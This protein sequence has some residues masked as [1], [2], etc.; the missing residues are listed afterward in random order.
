[1]EERKTFREITRGMSLGQK[2]MYFWYYYKWF[3]L[4]G[5]GFVALAIWIGVTIHAE[6]SKNYIAIIEMVNCETYSVDESDFFS[7]FFEK[8]G[9]D[10]ETYLDVGTTMEINLD[11]GGPTSSQGLQILA[12]EFTSGE[13]DIFVSDERLFEAEAKNHAFEDLR[14]V[15]PEKMLRQ[16]EDKLYYFYDEDVDE[17]IPIGL[18][19]DESLV[20]QNEHFYMPEDRPIIGVGSKWQSTEE[21]TIN[22]LEYFMND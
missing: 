18:R 10:E 4:L 1:M 12:A 8:Y 6:T 9:Y 22:L 20:C 7:S 17:D 5:I 3:T 14:E 21:D 15:L 13:L 19:L 2:I 11:N 16:Y